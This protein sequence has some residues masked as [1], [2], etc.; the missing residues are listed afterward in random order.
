MALFTIPFQVQ[1]LYVIC[2][3]QRQEVEE[4]G[5][6]IITIDSDSDESDTKY[7]IPNH[8]LNCNTKDVPK[9]EV[10]KEVNCYSQLQPNVSQSNFTRLVTNF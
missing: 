10:R 6:P 4:N 7:V 2:T 3:I 9:T 1:L 8:I 5:I